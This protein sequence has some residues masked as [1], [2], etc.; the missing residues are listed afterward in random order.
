MTTPPL[1]TITPPDGRR[2]LV[3]S[4]GVSSFYG[5]GLYGL[6][7]ALALSTH[8][9]F[10]PVAAIEFG[11]TDLVL[12][13]LREQSC[14]E[15]HSL[16]AD[17]W[18]ALAALSAPHAAIDAPVLVG[19]GNDLYGGD[20]A[21]ART[22]TG[23]PPIGVTFF[24]RAAL[25]QAGRERANEFAMIIAGS[26]WNEAM[27]RANGII[28]TT[29][30][31]QGVDT[32]IF[33]PAPRSGRF[34]DRFVIFSG[35]KLEYRKGQDLVVAAFRVFQQRHKEALLITAW[36]TPWYWRDDGMA[37]AT[38]TA[39]IE[40]AVDGT[41]DTARW[42]LAN[43]IPSDAL[44]AL[45]R[46][47]NI[48]LPHIVREAD[49]ALFP[50][51]CEGGTNLPAMECMACGVPVI[52]SANTGHMDLLVDDAVALRLSHQTQPVA[53]GYDTQEWGESDVEEIIEALETVWRDRQAATAIGRRGADFISSMTW[54]RQTDRLLGVIE[55][56]LP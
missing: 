55:P 53:D 13:P 46:T 3:F 4:W 40:Q 9:V 47:P 28:A 42:A 18:A 34:R 12:D 39:P 20:A 21:G 2:P 26:S 36:S 48:A 56:F 31:L 24:E 27:L 43:G 44:I 54:Q 11:A 41:V 17:L 15:L 22:L 38:G 49:V 29:T 37:A 7:L 52:L 23:Q 14:A 10:C 19:L 16:S 8:P 6:N 50:N 33:H 30:V 32:S 45:G 1:L 25:S 51:R 5:W 35:G